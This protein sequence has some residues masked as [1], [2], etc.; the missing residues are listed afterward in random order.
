MPIGGADDLPRFAIV[1]GKPQT[2]RFRFGDDL[3]QRPLEQ[4]QND[5]PSISMYSPML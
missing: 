2:Q 5:G 3:P 4:R 1:L